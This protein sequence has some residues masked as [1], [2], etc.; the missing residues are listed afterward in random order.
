MAFNILIIDDSKIIRSVIKKT[1]EISGI[2]VG[3][4]LEASNGLE[5]L[6][7][8]R[9]NWIDL[10]FADLNMPVM[11]G[12]EML[13]IMAQEKLLQKTPVL[14]CSTE[15][16]KSRIEELFK[17]GVRAFIRKPITPEILRN[18]VREVMGDYDAG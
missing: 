1:L 10:V 2:P 7:V 12:I 4:I 3:T 11:N 8:M 16:S 18:V 15:G 6:T 5:G 14:I 13:D 9:E 17:K